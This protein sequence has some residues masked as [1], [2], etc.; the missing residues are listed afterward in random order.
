MVKIPKEQ[1]VSAELMKQCLNTG[2][3]DVSRS[4]VFIA[5]VLQCLN[6]DFTYMMP[7]AGIG[8]NPDQKRW[9]LHINPY[10]FC[11]KLNQAQRKAVLI[12]EIY[13]VLNKHPFRVPFLKIN[14][15]KRQLMNIAADMAINQTIKDLPSGCPQCPPVE[16]GQ[17]CANPTCPGRCINV[18]DYY[19]EDEKTGK[20]SP[21]PTMQAMEIYYEKLLT[22]FKD[23]VKGDGEGQCEHCDGTGEDPN[24]PG[25]PCPECGGDGQKKGKGIPREFDSHKWDGNGDETE[26]LEATDELV[27]RAM[28]KQSL[29]YDQLPGFIKDLLDDIKAR[30][31]EL[32][33]R[34]IILAALKR[35]ASGHERKSTW[36]R[37]SKRY[38]ELAPGTRVGD[39]PRLRLYLDS[40]G[41]ISTEELNEFLGIVDEFLKVGSRKCEIAFFH[42]DLYH[43]QPYKLGE[44]F[45]R[46]KVQ[47]GGTDL[48]G[49]FEDIV[50]NPC[51][52]NLVIT[53]GCY[54]DVNFEAML[55][56]NQ[57]L[58][59]TLF[60][61]SRQGTADHPI[62]R[63][64]TIK[65]PESAKLRGDKDLEGK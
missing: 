60:I 37:K 34:G 32:N 2:I 38:G 48:T 3:Y 21:W 41:S 33:Y 6:M 30:K 65:V 7:T 51:D 4:H 47:S 62:K 44:R 29:S 36:A 64:E 50:K 45:D 31:A 53:D 24:A 63:L 1:E 18:N 26:M 56:P 15:S 57:K 40:S 12:H 19:D 43:K 8:Y 14:A 10:F 20:R 27:K 11:I 42:T 13:H 52:L 55:R 16:S 35:H 54:S 5:G 25:Q 23:M 61:I 49:V 22:K 46:K 9:D 59:Q 39:L 58:S 28:V 17:P